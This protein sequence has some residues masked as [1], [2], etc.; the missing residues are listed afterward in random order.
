MSVSPSS[1]RSCR[2]PTSS[3]SRGSRSIRLLN[4]G[5]KE[6]LDEVSPIEDFTEQFQLYFGKHQ[7]NE[8][9]GLRGGVPR[10]GHHV[11]AAPVRRGHLRQQGDR[12]DQG[13]G[14]LHGGLPHDD[15]AGHLHHQR[16]RACR[17][18][19]AGALPGRL[20]LARSSTRPPTRTSTS[21]RSSP[22]AARGS[23]STS[24]RRTPSACASTASAASTSPCFLK[25]LGWTADEILDAVR[26]RPLDPGHPGEGPRRDP[27]GGAR[28]HLPQ[29]PS[30]RAAH[31]RVRARRCSRTS[32]STRSATTWPRSGRHKV[33]KKLGAGRRRPAEA[34]ARPLQGARR[35]GQPR[36]EGVGAVQGTASS[37]S[38]SKDEHGTGRA[39][40]QGRPHVRGHAEDG[41]LPGA[42]CTPARRATTPT[43]S[44]TSATAASAA[45]AS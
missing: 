25:A 19:P 45:S 14:S 37:A 22:A 44:T 13:A 10:Q 39:E 34:A 8:V 4:E 28:G 40:V 1:T 41:P 20:L 23:S 36:Q 27:G 7:F 31:G 16:H 5:I 6:V 42:G 32:S 30:G 21:P 3:R 9:R 33:D 38:C 43:T 26:Q 18:L 15:R 17:R 24:T 2:S 29:A 12:R 35:A 11:L